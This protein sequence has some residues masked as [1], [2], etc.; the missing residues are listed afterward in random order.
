MRTCRVN[1]GGAQNSMLNAW[2]STSQLNKSFSRLAQKPGIRFRT[3][4]SS[5]DYTSSQ[6]IESNR[7]A[8]KANRLNSG[9]LGLCSPSLRQFVLYQTPIAQM[10]SRCFVAVVRCLSMTF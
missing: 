4:S 1:E 3:I 7:L 6:L 8:W 10:A 9:D 5:V 2:F